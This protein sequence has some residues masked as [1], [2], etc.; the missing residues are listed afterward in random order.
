MREP[1]HFLNVGRALAVNAHIGLERSGA[2]N[3]LGECQAGRFEI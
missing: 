3:V 2:T 1:H